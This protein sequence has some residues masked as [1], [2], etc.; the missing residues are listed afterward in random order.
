M[1]VHISLPEQL[2]ESTSSKMDPLIAYWGGRASSSPAAHFYFIGKHSGDRHHPGRACELKTL[3]FPG[4]MAFPSNARMLLS[5]DDFRLRNVTCEVRYADAYLLYDRTGSV[6][7]DLRAALTELKVINATPVQTTFQFKD[8]SGAIELGQS[9]LHDSNP[10]TS[11]EKFGRQCKVYFDVVLN[12]LDVKVFTR[13]GLR[14]FWRKKFDNMEKVREALNGLKLSNVGGKRFGVAEQLDE[15]FFRWEGEQT[16]ALLRLKA[17]MGKIDVVLPPELEVPNH[18]I[19]SQVNTLLL[20]VD[21]YT[22]APVELAQWDALAWIPQSA[23]IVR[24]EIDSI[25][26]H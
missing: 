25:L 5:I 23:R 20:D 16:G 17:E 9:R 13:V 24:K 2:C 1:R 3:W 6:M 21:Y 10:D 7:N 8:G 4:T 26:S 12:A 19:H 15:L 22:V 14:I 11:L 18:E